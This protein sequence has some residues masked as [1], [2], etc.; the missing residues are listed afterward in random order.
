LAPQLLKLSF[1]QEYREIL[2]EPTGI[3]NC[4][5][6]IANFGL[7]IPLSAIRH[8]QFLICAGSTSELL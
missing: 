8:L 1:G 6:R 2:K 3:W 7:D 4:G 5:M